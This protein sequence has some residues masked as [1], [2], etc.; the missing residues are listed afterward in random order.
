MAVNIVTGS[1]LKGLREAG[2]RITTICRCKGYQHSIVSVPTKSGWLATMGTV[3]GQKWLSLVMH[4]TS[5]N[6]LEIREGL[7]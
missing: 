3:G 5:H 2:C 1:M 6:Q 7:I 4:N